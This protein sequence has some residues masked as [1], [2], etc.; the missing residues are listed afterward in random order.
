MINT[1]L[2]ANRGE[3]A[4]RIIRTCRK[5]GIR[6]VAV[7]SDADV[8]GLH[9]RLADTAVAIG[10]APAV[11]SYLNSDKIIEVAKRTGADAVH[12]GFGFLAENAD[13]A[14]ACAQAGLIFIGPSPESMQA[15]G[16]KRAAKALV[17]AVG[18]PVLA[19]YVGEG[20]PDDKLIAEAA[21]VGFPLMVKAADGGG[22]K[23]MR[24]VYDAAALPEALAAARREAL[25]AFGSDELILERALLNP[26]H[27][28]VQVV[29][30]YHGNTI[31]LGERECSI[32]RRHQKIIEETPSP[33]VDAELRRRIGETAV[34]AAESVN[35]HNVGTVEF[36]LDEDGHFYFL[37]MNTRLQVEHPV[38]EMVTGVD[39]VEWQI[40]I[41]EGEPLPLRQ[42]DVQL[43]GHAI[44]ARVYAEDPANEFLPT[45]G[46]VLLWQTPR[47]NIRIDS[48]VQTGD[49]VSVYYDPMLAKI[50]AYGDDRKTAVRRLQRALAKTALFGLQSNLSFLQAVLRH[51][52]FIAGDFDTAFIAQHLADLDVAEGDLPLA[53]V[54]ASLAQFTTHPQLTQN[55]GFWRNSLHRPQLYRYLVGDDVVDVSVTAV[56]RQP[57]S[58]QISMA[59]EVDRTFDVVL[60]EVDGQHLVVT[61]DGWRKTAVFA[62]NPLKEDGIE[63]W[64]QSLDGSLSFCSASL[65]P[66]PKTAVDS[67]G[68]LLAPMPGSVLELMVAEGDQVAPGQAL[69][70]LE[71]MKME[72]TI[73]AAG[74]GIVTEIY[75]AVGDIVD[76]AVQLLQ[77]KPLE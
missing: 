32:Q 61:I 46:P 47:E 50:I 60:N 2:I 30:D 40:R 24:L 49:T 16:N 54:V 31:H 36:L 11:D 28:E 68:S 42:D 29:G 69:M 53:L 20:Q 22:G 70:K 21:R 44:E 7:Y 59:T 64:V 13:F 14:T 74:D 55:A 6:S 25:Q 35:Y 10:P 48:G 41:A 26:R 72:H 23:G 45:T 17:T 1:I 57:N 76:A 39:L 12:P 27:I 8:D 4:C 62:Q 3:V 15:M 19:G 18:V 58:Y 9:V 34:L 65:L 71:A 43:V 75:F 67:G 33:V 37:E 5:L 51:P 38:T 73:R 66:A 56:L 52:A 77:I 63:W